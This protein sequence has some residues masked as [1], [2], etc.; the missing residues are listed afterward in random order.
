MLRWMDG[1]EIYGLTETFMVEGVG[2]AAAWSEIDET[3]L[4][5]TNPATGTYH[6]R[7]TASDNFPQ[8]MRRALSQTKEVA[9][10]A[11]RFALTALPDTENANTRLTLVDYRN[12]VNGEQFRINC[13][14]EGSIHA[15]GAGL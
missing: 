14:T 11:Y 5:T 2:G 8:R 4:S 3:N 9:G 7:M 10:F 12:V 6:M 13:G 15:Y 1:F